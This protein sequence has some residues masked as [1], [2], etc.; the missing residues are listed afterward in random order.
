MRAQNGAAEVNED[1]NAVR[2]GGV[3]DG[4]HDAHRVGADGIVRI[5]NAGGGVDGV[6]RGA[7]LCGEGGDAA[8]DVGVVR[9]EDEVNH[10][11]FSLVW[12]GMAKTAPESGFCCVIGSGGRL[13]IYAG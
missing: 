12:A 5:I 8:G 2:V 1:E 3:F 11:G 13:Y 10:R 7:H 4:L 6:G 9:D